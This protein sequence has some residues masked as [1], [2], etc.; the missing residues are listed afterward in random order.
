MKVSAKIINSKAAS[1]IIESNFSEVEFT[2][3]AK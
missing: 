3:K 1:L 2:N